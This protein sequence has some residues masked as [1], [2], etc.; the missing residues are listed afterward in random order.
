MRPT[1]GNVEDDAK[2]VGNAAANAI[3]SGIGA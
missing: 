3:R 1:P 2:V